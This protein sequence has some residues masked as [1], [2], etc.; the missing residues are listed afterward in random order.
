MQNKGFL[1]SCPKGL[2]L[3]PELAD[4]PNPWLKRLIQDVISQKVVLRAICMTADEYSNHW[5]EARDWDKKAE[6]GKL[7][8]AIRPFLTDVLWVVEVSVP[9]LFPTNL[10]KLG[11]IVL[12]AEKPPSVVLDFGHFLC[13]RVPGRLLLLDGVSQEGIP[14]FSP[15]PSQL[16]SHVPLYGCSDGTP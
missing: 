5:K 4:Q 11:E 15:I 8:D 13:A 2:F 14:S 7:C 12:T 3:L 6:N 16:E 9:E 1:S 10:R